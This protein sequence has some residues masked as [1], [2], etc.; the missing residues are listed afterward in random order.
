MAQISKLI[1]KS[2][3]INQAT[4]GER[5]KFIATTNCLQGNKT[6]RQDVF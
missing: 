1:Q 5:V 2:E 3:K 6:A 4:P